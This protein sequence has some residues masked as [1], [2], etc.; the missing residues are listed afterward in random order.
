VE[1]TESLNEAEEVIADTAVK[2]VEVIVDKHEKG[3]VELSDEEI[4]E[5]IE[6]IGKNIGKVE[7]KVKET[8]EQVDVVA[9]RVAVDEIANDVAKEEE[10][11]AEEAA[12]EEAGTNSSETTE[13]GEEKEVA[14]DENT[15]NE[16]KVEELKDRPSEAELLLEEAR[17]FLKHGDLKSALQ[18]MKQSAALA[19]QTQVEVKTLSESIPEEE[20]VVEVSPED[21]VEESVEA[22]ADESVEI[23]DTVDEGSLQE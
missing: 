7:E 19:K 12:A 17:D 14:V 23:S 22:S 10:D 20:Q 18:K 8:A 13:E 6:K 16:D 15:V 5:T 2:A 11:A 3:E 1:I 4:I 9:D 21:K